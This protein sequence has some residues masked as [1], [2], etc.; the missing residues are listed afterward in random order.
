MKILRIPLALIFS[1]RAAKVAAEQLASRANAGLI[2]SSNPLDE[3]VFLGEQK[4]RDELAKAL[5]LQQAGES[6][7]V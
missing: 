2:T 5:E 1:S 4:A 7:V 3:I 6:L